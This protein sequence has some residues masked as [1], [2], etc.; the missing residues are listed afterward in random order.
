MRPDR[1]NLRGQSSQR[2]QNSGLWWERAFLALSNL[3][4]RFFSRLR[5]VFGWVV[6]GP[7]LREWFTVAGTSM[8]LSGVLRSWSCAKLLVSGKSSTSMSDDLSS[9]DEHSSSGIKRP[10]AAPPADNVWSAM[11]E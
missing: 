1:V 2:K 7:L 10:P 5:S 4:I 6:V 8:E 3:P 11:T 9:D